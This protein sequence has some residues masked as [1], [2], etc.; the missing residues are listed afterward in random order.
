M[1]NVF[2]LN[3][4]KN[5]MVLRRVEN[6]FELKQVGRRGLK[7]EKGDKGDQGDAAN[8]PV[9]SVNGKI[10]H[11]VINKNDVGLGNADNTSDTNKPVS[12]AQQTALNKKS[13]K[14]STTVGLV[15]SGADFEVNDTNFHTQMRAAILQVAAVGAS[16]EATLGVVGL[17]TV[18]L[19]P[20]VYK[21]RG[22]INTR[23]TTGSVTVATGNYRIRGAGMGRT[24][25]QRNFDGSGS[26][27]EL[28]GNSIQTLVRKIE[29]E[30]VTIDQN[31]RGA[32]WGIVSGWVQDSDFYRCEFK[33]I[34]P[35][36]TLAALL[37]GKFQGGS[38][39]YEAN[40][41][42]V[43]GS[44]FDMSIPTADIASV[45]PATGT[46]NFSSPYP[47]FVDG[48][49]MRFLDNAP[50]PLL[51]NTNYFVIAG[52]DTQIQIAS[53][54]E[55]AINHVPMTFNNGATASGRVVN[56]N[57]LSWEFCSALN[58]RNIS[59]ASTSFRGGVATNRTAFLAYNSEQIRI[60]DCFIDHQTVTVG[61]RGAISIS[62]VQFDQGKLFIDQAHDVIVDNVSQVSWGEKTGYTNGVVFRGRYKTIS[63]DETPWYIPYV[64][65]ASVDPA[66]NVITLDASSTLFATGA[67]I[68]LR[69]LEKS[70]PEGLLAIHPI[71]YFNSITNFPT[72]GSPS[73]YYVDRTTR[74]CYQWSSRFVGSNEG[75][76]NVSRMG[77][78][79]YYSIYID[80]THIK[81]ATSLADA[82]SGT[83]V[84]MTTAAFGATKIGPQYLFQCENVVISN[85]TIRGG[86]PNAIYSKTTTGFSDEVADCRDLTLSN[87]KIDGTTGIGVV[88]FADNLKIDNVDI[89]NANTDNVNSQAIG[90]YVAGRN[91]TLSN[92]S[93]GS[94][95]TTTD[96]AVDHL[97]FAHVFGPTATL[98]LSNISYS[99]V[100]DVQYFNSSG[101]LQEAPT[102]GITVI[103]DDGA[104]KNP[105]RAATTV[106][107]S[108]NTQNTIGTTLTGQVNGVLTSIDGVTLA[109]YDIVLVKNE[110]SQKKN[111]LY[112]VKDVGSISTPW[113]LERTADA[114][115]AGQFQPGFMT[116]ISEGTTQA[117]S[118]WIFNNTTQP[119]LGVTNLTFKGFADDA[120]VVHKTSAETIAGVK[121]F[122]ASPIV[123]TATTSTQAVN[124]SQLDTKADTTTLT[125]HTT[126][127]SNPHSVT[128][129]QVGLANVNNT[130]DLDKPTPTVT[131]TLINTKS[132]KPDDGYLARN[133]DFINCSNA[134][135]ALGSNGTV[136]AQKLNTDSA[137]TVNNINMFITAAGTGL[138]SG[139]CF[140]ALYDSSKNLLATTADQSTSWN[141]TGIK[142]M[143]L[144]T[145][146][147]VLTGTFYVVVWANGTTRPAFSKAW[148]A[149][150]TS[151]AA[152]NGGLAAANSRWASADAS[153]TTT[154]PAT[155]AAFTAV[156]NPY[157]VAVS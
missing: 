47:Y 13:T 117:G 70:L 153:V 116:V 126:N 80:D 27:F 12:T 140:A 112:Y 1:K 147:N 57:G 69:A 64:N 63:G 100:N 108:T 51:P 138:V 16:I 129:A 24:V 60:S 71:Q 40:N 39:A 2:K 111:G 132:N 135:T 35:G 26:M 21:Q 131:Q 136:Y 11:V 25:V 93:F 15:G 88:A 50:A 86:K 9:Q 102:A 128:K 122:S 31:R 75:A 37:T 68:S 104:I 130:A 155:L 10:G 144:L 76:Y 18:D 67:K 115:Y 123:P 89:I 145:P 119:T 59:F 28:G 83:A 66:T 52:T 95:N 143:A 7:G 105:A 152:V 14:M 53:S 148:A 94:K 33:N 58:A 3:S 150:T 125:S 96:I 141:S 61:S 110:P 113:I 55:N 22:T 134:S 85:T 79:N 107:L 99:S 41:I 118:V 48:D 73:T 97:R 106:A 103:R 149:G 42:S 156:A 142:T 84:D 56:F 98:R 36:A 45:V 139:Q 17:T 120:N 34:N 5:T 20:G 151:A 91:M 38:D 54:Q 137:I 82:Q 23:T 133:F 101:N 114:Y 77:S 30:D 72:T 19:L 49:R 74:I 87:V 8:A 81:L 43:R 90:L 78:D 62:N 92:V 154:A 6:T 157:W 4:Q 146:Q 109:K 29:V 32:G 44:I 65:V 124:K 121:T 127:V 46:V